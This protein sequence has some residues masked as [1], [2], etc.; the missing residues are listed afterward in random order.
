MS[1][2]LNEGLVNYLEYYI[3]LEYSPK[4]AVMINGKWGSG[5]TWFI[6]N[7]KD[8]LDMDEITSFNISLYGK[9]ST[10]QIDDDLYKCMHPILSS[11]GMILAGALGKAL[12]KSTVKFNL[13]N[14]KKDTLNVSLGLPELNLSKLTSEPN[15]S[16]IIFDDFERASIDAV[17][18]FGYINSLTENHGCKVII[19]TDESQSM[20]KNKSDETQAYKNSKEKVVGVT[21]NYHPETELAV[22][23]FIAEFSNPGLKKQLNQNKELLTDLLAKTESK[24]LR[25]CRRFLM[26]FERLYLSMTKEHRSESHLISVLL[27][28]LFILKY[29]CNLRTL[30][31]S[32]LIIEKN[33]KGHALSNEITN[34]Y[35]IPVF[36]KPILPLELWDEIITLNRFNSKKIKSA[37]LDSINKDSIFL[38]SWLS[39]INYLLLTPDQFERDLLDV[40]SKLKNNEYKNENIIK[41]IFGTAIALMKDGIIKPLKFKEITEECYKCI[42]NLKNGRFLLEPDNEFDH[43][44]SRESWGGY[45]FSERSSNEFKKFA[46]FIDAMSKEQEADS[47]KG[48]IEEIKKSIKNNDKNL[49]PLLNYNKLG[50]KTYANKPIFSHANPKEIAMAAIEGNNLINLEGI[51]VSRYETIYKESPLIAEM[52]FLENLIEEF[53]LIYH[54]SKHP[55]DKV[56]IRRFIDHGLK[57][58]L[59]SF[60]RHTSN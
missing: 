60:V 14:E 12:L 7:L 22:N 2:E 50:V 52:A 32:E 24:N 4:F 18:L 9:S 33:E 5:K 40:E 8:V 23:N 10:S 55:L 37:L 43:P 25:F 59:E 21:I 39:L 26:E 41:H 56:K 1:D 15:K 6:E 48:V 45:S 51:L 13:D 54:S 19:L 36:A 42:E 20:L 11:K 28:N 35:K 3:G 27:R 46:D 47:F 30:S 16:L 44:F 58:P 29:E 57:K 38:E 49:Y 31:P 34:K 17:E 53:E